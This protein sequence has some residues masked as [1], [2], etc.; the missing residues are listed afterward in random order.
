MMQNLSNDEYCQKTFGMSFDEYVKRSVAQD[1]IF[2][3][4]IEEEQLTVTEYEYKGDLESFA[5]DMG[6]TNKDSF[7]EKYG[8]DKIVR[9][10]LIQKAQNI[11]MDNAIYE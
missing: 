1:L 10:M 9:A 4:I 7:V 6:F 3:R 8:K 5:N 2:Q 11:V